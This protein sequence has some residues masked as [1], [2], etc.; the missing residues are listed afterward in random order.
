MSAAA[1]ASV[2]RTARRRGRTAVH[3]HLWSSRSVTSAGV[4]GCE[5]ALRPSVWPV[6][7]GG[8][9][10]TVHP[11]E[12]PLADEAVN[13]RTCPIALP[14]EPAP[15]LKLGRDDRRAHARGAHALEPPARLC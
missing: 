9:D 12:P 15:Q 5:R 6:L 11:A 7:A 10:V 4:L 2:T 13:E 3:G 1:N 14:G 8:H